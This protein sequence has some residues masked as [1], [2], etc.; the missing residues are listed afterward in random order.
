[1]DK[2]N[3]KE[4]NLLKDEYG[5]EISLFDENENEH[6]FHLILELIAGDKHYAYFQSADE[7]DEEGDIEVLEVVKNEA[8][9]L[10]LEFI[11]DDEEWESAAELFDEWSDSFEE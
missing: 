4:T 10:D 5:S 9:E 11:E 7:S 6:S 2:K 3:I 8:G 1:M